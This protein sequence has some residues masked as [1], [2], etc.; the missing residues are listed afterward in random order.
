MEKKKK[1]EEESVFFITESCI[2]M[3]ELECQKAALIVCLMTDDLTCQN[4]T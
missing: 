2:E 1:E 3:S 4:N